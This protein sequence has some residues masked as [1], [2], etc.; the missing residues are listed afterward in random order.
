MAVDSKNF[1]RGW[2]R[3][4]PLSW[5]LRR[6]KFQVN[7]EVLLYALIIV[8]AV[9]TRFY[10]LASRAL[11]HDEGV[12]AFYSWQ[13]YHGGGYTQEPWRHGPFL[14]H[15]T[16]LM[17]WFFGSAVATARFSTALFG[18]FIVLLPLFLRHEL[19]RWGALTAS[20]LLM[21]SPLFLY[22]S[23]FI[24]ED[25]FVT[26]SVL[27]LFIALVRFV[28]KPRAGWWYIGMLALGLL[29][30]TKEVSFFYT[31]I[32]F[33]FL[34][35]WLCWQLAPRLILIFGAYALLALLAFSFVMRLSPLPAIPF[36]NPAAIPQ[37]VQQFLLH[38][39]FLSLIFLTLLGLVVAFFAFREVAESR[40]EFLVRNGQIGPYVGG[41]AALFMPY[42]VGTVAYAVGW[43]GR[44][45]QVLF[46]GLFFAF[47]FYS[48]FF[49]SFFSTL[50]GEAGLLSGLFYW[51]AQQGV[52]R[53]SQPWY[54]Y[55]FLLP[56][57]EP[58]A[59][60][61]GLL[62][63]AFILVKAAGYGLRRTVHTQL[64][65]AAQVKLVP[66]VQEIEELDA[67]GQPLPSAA[68][69]QAEPQ[70]V[71]VE[72][73]E[74][75]RGSV[76]WPNRRKREIHPHFFALFLVFVAFSS[77]AVYTWA[78]EKMPWLTMELALPFVLLTAYFFNPIWEGLDEF[79]SSGRQHEVV[80]WGFNKKIVLWGIV[81]F[82]TL[83][84]VGFY[85]LLDASTATAHPDTDV[86]W[87]SNLTAWKIGLGVFALLALGG[88]GLLIFVSRRNEWRVTVWT[89]AGVI[90]VLMSLFL[91]RTAF[92]FS[93]E[94]GDTPTELGIYSQAAPDVPRLMA[95][96]DTFSTI[97]PEQKALPILYDTELQVPFNFYLREYTA[98]KMVGDF[99]PETLQANGAGT[100]N[101]Y[102]IIMAIN[103]KTD[104]LGTVAQ[105]YV[106]YKR[107]L[108]WFFDESLYRDFAH[109]SEIEKQQLLNQTAKTTVK[110]SKGTVI[111]TEGQ[112]MSQ[113]I[114]DNADSNH[115]LDKVYSEN[116]HSVLGLN[117]NL[118][119][120]STA[121]LFNSH[122]LQ[123]LWRYV[124]FREQPG[125]FW[126][127]Y[128]FTLYVRKDVVGLWRQY[129]DLVPVN[130]NPPQ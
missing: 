81:L 122:N 72:V 82:T 1:N 48:I 34:F 43:L 12:H 73:R 115:L 52:A 78:S 71:E 97:M 108:R 55:L 61:F 109:T 63:A 5:S 95:Q 96:L 110:D 28:A 83:A 70:M 6:I 22:Y 121:D 127:V 80:I 33:G 10:D 8:V 40:R 32:L 58:L 114:L 11:D 90:F 45:K 4:R 7:V 35:V 98:A 25:V 56:L 46:L 44:H 65:P 54:Y 105:N 112:V 107:T 42:E 19:G 27:V 15:V 31:A 85:L 104:Q 84:L 17:F 94:N 69:P 118:D 59:L 62:S 102:P 39:I 9:A 68:K 30:C 51:L 103:S 53:G 101:S 124:F 23:R 125:E 3:T 66:E 93:Y 74:R 36:D 75:E 99:K 41:A 116:G 57:Y 123:N 64:V 119:V 26:F 29:Y 37:F 111:V 21:I 89:F 87:A 120:T 77:L 126:G 130:L 13:L 38:P 86:G 50:D 76:L 117:A 20:F 79:F 91:M 60:A 47:A 18:V 100:L 24:R 16:A 49:T 113:Q 2:V 129:G 88:V 67:D 14:Y 92:A 128:D 106:A